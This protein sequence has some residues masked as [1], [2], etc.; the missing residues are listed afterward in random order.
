LAAEGVRRVA[1]KLARFLLLS[2]ITAF[3]V[4]VIALAL[5]ASLAAT[6]LFV[7]AAV[8][9]LATLVLLRRR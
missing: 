4:G 3:T 6:V 7:V 2:A 9:F 8:A 5:G 1:V